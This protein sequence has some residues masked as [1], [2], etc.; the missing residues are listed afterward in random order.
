MPVETD[1]DRRLFV[2]DDDFAVPVL[3]AHSGGMAHFYAIFDADYQLLSSA[4]LDAG[5]E[6]ASPQI[7]ACSADLPPAAAQ[8]D[9]VTVA[10]GSYRVVEIKP[11][12]T[13]MTIVRLQ[14]M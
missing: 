1:D 5:V 10:G 3:W 9:G 14:A 11:D 4:F 8:G 13:G 6:G 2:Q 7:H 12:G